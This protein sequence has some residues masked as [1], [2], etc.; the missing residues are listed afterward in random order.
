MVLKFLSPRFA[1]TWVF[2]GHWFWRRTGWVGV[3]AFYLASPCLPFAFTI[4]LFLSLFSLHY[5]NPLHPLQINSLLLLS[6]FALPKLHAL[7]LEHF[8][9]AVWGWR[10]A[11][12]REALLSDPLGS[13]WR[14]LEEKETR[15]HLLAGLYPSGLLSAFPSC[16][17]P[18]C[19]VLFL[20]ASLSLSASSLF[21]AHVFSSSCISPLLC[22]M[23]LVFI[24]SIKHSFSGG[25]GTFWHAADILKP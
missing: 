21:V 15:P 5:P 25:G 24:S 17:F 2:G 3:D 23:C 19:L 16:P 8:V 14:G 22:S 7:R 9:T 13:G 12:R 1:Y 18:A 11:W 4:S 20:Q 6:A 10:A